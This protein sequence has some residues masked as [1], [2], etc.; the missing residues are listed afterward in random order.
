MEEIGDDSTDSL[1]V[2][3][4]GFEDF[5]L[6]VCWDDIIIGDRGWHETGVAFGNGYFITGASY[7]QPAVTIQHHE[8]DEGVLLDHVAMEWL[9]GLNDLDAEVWGVQYLVG[10]ADVLTMVCTVLW[11]YVIVD[12]L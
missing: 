10:C 9:C 11:I 3:D 1:L 7:S 5:C 2:V 8:D 4:E 12:G 6:A